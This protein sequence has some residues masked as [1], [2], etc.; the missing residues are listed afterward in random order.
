MPDAPDDVAAFVADGAGA[1]VVAVAAG[2]DAVAF[3]DVVAVEDLVVVFLVLFFF[4]VVVVVVAA[5][6]VVAA[7]AAAVVAAGAAAVVVVAAE[8]PLV[9]VPVVAPD[10]PPDADAP[11]CG[12]VIART[13]PRLPKVPTPINSP[14]F[15]PMFLSSSLSLEIL[16]PREIQMLRHGIDPSEYRRI[17]PHHVPRQPTASDHRHRHRYL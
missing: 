11:N 17:A 7:G 16:I 10:K 13:A 9:V 4:V 8:V 2:V 14:R 15:A 3:A 5:A 6:G 1:A 12:G